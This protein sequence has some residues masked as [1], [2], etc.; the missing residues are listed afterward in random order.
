MIR[1]LSPVVLPFL[2][3][4]VFSAAVASAQTTIPLGSSA[5]ITLKGFVSATFFGQD[6]NFVAS[7]APAAGGQA[8]TGG[9]F[10]NGQNAEFPA[11]PEASGDRWFWGGDVRNT[12]LT[13]AFDGPKIVNDWKVNATVEGDF[14]GGFNG[15]GSFSGQ[16]P[17]PRLR[18]A[19][20]DFTN[21]STTIRM[22][23][24]WAPL[25]GNVA[26]SLSHIAFPLGYGAAGDIGWRF[27]G[28]FLY[29]NLTPKSAPVN[30]DLVFAVMSNNWS[31]PP[32]TTFDQNNTGNGG[33]PQFEL[34]VNVG[35]KS[36]DMSWSSYVVGHWDKKDLNGPGN[37]GGE[38]LDGKALELGAK[39]QIGGFLLQGNGYT[40]TAIGQNFGAITQFG[41]ID[42][43]GGWVQAGYE[44]AKTWG[45][46]GFWGTD[47]PS[48]HDV[49]K[50]SPA[51]ARLKSTMIAAML[52][53]KSGPLAFG[54][55]YMGD[56]LRSG[57]VPT[58][59]RGRQVALSALYNF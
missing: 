19:F 26:V 9:G 27:P 56:K 16:Q 50:F 35:G 39:F 21:G 28:I 22:G 29:Q 1:R 18:L 6:Q 51:T 46:Y 34:R 43:V 2:A 55:E 17:D 38:S 41:D 8:F 53:W 58:D 3:L 59:T 31:A 4:A 12:R 15:T 30:A 23:Q 14:F 48:D 47:D 42:S 10:G 24:Q 32:G 37:S 49:L 45:V 13:L 36:G 11:V 7:P 5:S 20:V 40:G 33:T 54:L 44:F 52:R 57:A 25:F